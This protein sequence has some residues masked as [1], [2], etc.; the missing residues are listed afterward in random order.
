MA[1]EAQPDNKKT[2]ALWA[3]TDP[4]VLALAL[5]YFGTSAGLYTLGLWAPQ[6]IG[7]FG[8]SPLQIGFINV[9]PNAIAIVGMILWARRSDRTGER[10]WHVVL[11]CL[12]ACVGLVL[13][14]LAHSA[15][16]VVTA[17]TLVNLGISAAKPPLWSMPSMML[18]GAAAAAGI[19][20]INAIGNLGGFVGPSVI[21]WLKDVTGGYAAGLY[22]VSATLAVSAVVTLVISRSLTRP[23]A[24][25]AV[26]TGD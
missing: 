26:A 22:V 7:Q 10:T 18:S 25:V 13:A 12:A 6:I 16:G 15:L 2:S 14:G 5:V 23:P 1:A 9:I 3:L 20:T 4:R 11:P 21:G 17:L 19:A 24:E 8:F